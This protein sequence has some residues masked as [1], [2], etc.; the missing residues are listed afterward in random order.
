MPVP[1]GENILKDVLWKSA[2][3]QNLPADRT[4]EMPRN[5]NSMRVE[6]ADWLPGGEKSQAGLR[7]ESEARELNRPGQLLG[8]RSPWSA[9]LK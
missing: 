4:R 3:Q 7:P 1:L 2:R 9:A 8:F 5:A 6:S